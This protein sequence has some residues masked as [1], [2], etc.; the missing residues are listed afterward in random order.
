MPIEL[1]LPQSM[2]QKMVE[3][4]EY[5]NLLKIANETEDRGY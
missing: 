5:E 1:N 4:L 3:F 2:L